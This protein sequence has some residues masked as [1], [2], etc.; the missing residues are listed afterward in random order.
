MGKALVVAIDGPAGSGKSTLG[1]ALAEQLGFLFFDTGVLYR[2]VTWFA[3]EC[4]VNVDEAAALV[5]L[6]QRAQPDVTATTQKDGRSGI[7][8]INGQDVTAAIREPRVDANVSAVSAHPAVRQALLRRQREIASRGRVVLVGRDIGTV[9]APDA[10]LK[11][12][13]DASPE[14][15]AARR[16]AEMRARGVQSDLAKVAEDLHRRDETDSGRAS[17]PLKAAPD[18][19]VIN[20]DALSIEDE[21]Q[22]VMTMLI[23]KGYGC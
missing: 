17:S 15:R 13:L 7:V 6:I 10:D 14:V 3:L 22:Q 9:V 18:A 16:F 23:K 1:Q 8:V 2:A 12:Y 19:I 20:S 5:R 21:V 11:I 4:D